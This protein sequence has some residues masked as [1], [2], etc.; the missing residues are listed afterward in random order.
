MHRS[1]H[2]SRPLRRAPLAVTLAL[3]CAALL[4]ATWPA[5]A[6]AQS[7]NALPSLG[8]PVSEDLSPGMERQIGEQIM[9]EIRRDPDYLDDPV[10]LEYLRALWQPL[11]EA[12]RV[13]G[14]IGDELALR[15]P[16]EPFLVRDRSVNAFALPG[17]FVGVHLGLIAVTASRDELAAVLAHELSHV[18]QRHIARSIA[19]SRQASILSI[20]ATILGALAASRSSD[21][22]AGRAVMTAGQGAAIQAQ[23]NFSRDMEREADRVGYGVMIQA[24]YSAAGMASMFEKLDRASRFNDSG[25]YPYLRSHPLTV[26]RIGEARSR[27]AADPG[28]ALTGSLLWHATMRARARVLMDTRSDNLRRLESPAPDLAS[29]VEASTPLPAASAAV[30]SAGVERLPDVRVVGTLTERAERLSTAY[31]SALAATLLRNWKQADISLLQAQALVRGASTGEAEALRAVQLLQV[32][33]LLERG[34]AARARTALEPL[35]Q[36]KPTRPVLMLQAQIALADP[37]RGSAE[38]QQALKR[39]A[40]ALQTW[41]ATHPGDALAWRTLGQ[42]WAPLE[43]PLRAL[44]AD[45]E[46]ALASGDLRGAIDRLRNAQRLARGHTQADFIELSV[47]DARLRALEAQRRALLAEQSQR[48]A[49][50]PQ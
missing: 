9:S 32:Q 3:S 27:S 6:R 38:G 31:A 39:S 20:V 8:D 10:L 13:R 24:G 35:A 29:A 1:S 15:Y 43:Q 44:R 25:D 47:I 5:P 11:L 36:G 50:P 12:A 18:T 22:T 45:A 26:D 7:P 30:R 48:G 23:L 19:P 4:H 42:V 46:A 17:G 37:A 49:A 33:S 41:V 21:P 16:F 34:D 14:E 28:P 40:E 2:R